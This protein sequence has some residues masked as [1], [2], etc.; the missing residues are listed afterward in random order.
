[1]DPPNLGWPAPVL[2]RCVAP[3][4]T[5]T[6]S[7]LFALRGAFQVTF[8]Y[9]NGNL[10]LDT[11]AVNDAMLPFGH[12]DGDGLGL[13][14]QAAD[15][16]AARRPGFGAYVGSTF[17]VRRMTLCQG[18][19]NQCTPPPPPPTA[20]PTATTVTATTTTTITTN[21]LMAGLNRGVQDLLNDGNDTAINALLSL[22]TGAL[23]AQAHAVRELA[24]QLSDTKQQLTVAVQNITQLQAERDTLNSRV[25]LLEA[26]AASMMTAPGRGAATGSRPSGQPPQVRG[27][28]EAVI[29]AAGTVSFESSQCAQTDLCDLARDVAAIKGKFDPV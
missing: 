19:S 10:F 18:A 17:E 25:V 8:K 13:A 22:E 29:M 9:E 11:W 7:F 5:H 15:L 14:V 12:N 3:W 1:M 20:G 23:G 4:L 2:P 28:G 6:H 21:T 26:W 27:E 16:S 24:Q